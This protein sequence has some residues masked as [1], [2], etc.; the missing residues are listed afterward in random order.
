MEDNIL[1]ELNNEGNTRKLYRGYY[2]HFKDKLYYVHDIAEHTETG[3]IMV[4]Y[5][6]LYGERKKYVREISMFLSKTDKEKY[7]EVTQEYRF[8]RFFPEDLKKSDEE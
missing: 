3:E 2:K 5:Q 4:F 7:P 6:A 1:Y 8:I